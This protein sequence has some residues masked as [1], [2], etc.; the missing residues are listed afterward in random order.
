[1]RRV[2]VFFYGLFMSEEL[3]KRRG[4]NPTNRRMTEVENFEIHVGKRASLL[5]KIG[6]SVWGIAF[7]LSAEEVTA[8][9]SEPAVA[10]YRPE[11]VLARSAR[12]EVFA[13]LC[14]NTDPSNDSI[15]DQAYLEKL[16]EIATNEEL[17]PAYL[18]LLSR[19]R[20]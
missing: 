5:P 19:L 15:A 9:Y 11:A 6:S 13:A 20:N 2:T 10:D 17:P 12:G 3:L 8:L 14:Y 16:I 7:D 18:V 4:L 1:M